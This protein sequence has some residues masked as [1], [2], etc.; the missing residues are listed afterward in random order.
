[1]E[2]HTVVDWPRKVVFVSNGGEQVNFCLE[3]L[4]LQPQ[5]LKGI[6]GRKGRGGLERREEEGWGDKEEEGWG[7][8]ER[9]V[10]ETGRGR[11]ERP[12]NTHHVTWTQSGHTCGG[13]GGGGGGVTCVQVYFQS[14]ERPGSHI[15]MKTYSLPPSSFSPPIRTSIPLSSSLPPYFSP[16]HI[17]SLPSLLL[18]SL[19]PLP[20]LSSLL[21]S[22]SLPV[23]C[24]IFQDA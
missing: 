22:Y 14:C 5:V 6:R 17:L 10:G 19:P 3:I 24:Q 15:A 8:G 2:D 20:F 7:D 4:S 18:P 1:M 11:E 16:F 13:G 12:G 21:L 9:R 23:V